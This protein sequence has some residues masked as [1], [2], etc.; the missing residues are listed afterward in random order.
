MHSALIEGFVRPQLIVLRQFLDILVA[1]LQVL[2][3]SVVDATVGPLGLPCSAVSVRKLVFL[4]FLGMRRVLCR[5]GL[6]PKR[7]GNLSLGRGRAVRP[8]A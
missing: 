6:L 8:A 1:K 3:V 4:L 7:G 5:A 2:Q